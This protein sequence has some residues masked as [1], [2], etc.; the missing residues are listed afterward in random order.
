MRAVCGHRRG[1]RQ[2]VRALEARIDALEKP[3]LARTE[4]RENVA[5][6]VKF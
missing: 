3:D 1:L 6:L 5:V 2:A 4:S